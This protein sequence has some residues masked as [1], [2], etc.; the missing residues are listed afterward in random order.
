ML[1]TRQRLPPR[2]W[3]MKRG[4]TGFS[5]WQALAHKWCR[6]L[7][8]LR[9]EIFNISKFQ[10]S[11]NLDPP[12]IINATNTRQGITRL[13]CLLSIATYSNQESATPWPQHSN[14]RHQRHHA[15]QQHPT[16]HLRPSHIDTVVGTIKTLGVS[17]G[18]CQFLPEKAWQTSTNI[19]CRQG[20]TFA[21]VFSIRSRSPCACW[22][23]Y[24]L[25]S[26][27]ACELKR[28]AIYD[29]GK[30]FDKQLRLVR[31]IHAFI[32]GLWSRVT[33]FP[34]HLSPR[35]QD[36]RMQDGKHP[37]SIYWTA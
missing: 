4:E 13:V 3:N 21:P 36:E 30:S 26:G 33:A 10:I 37:K 32:F 17:I 2:S 5:T 22:E 11:A 29:A 23:C 7:N 24:P 28:P 1:E 31:L 12:I 14:H 18:Q 6:T 8:D 27:R 34:I 25:Q 16:T 15:C 9:D 20:T 35:R 19:G